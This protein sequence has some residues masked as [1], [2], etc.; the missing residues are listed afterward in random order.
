MKINISQ[1]KITEG[2]LIIPAI[3]TDTPFIEI[4]QFQLSISNKIFSAKKDT[5]YIIEKES[6]IYIV[7]GLGKDMEHKVL[8]DSFR[9][10]SFKNKDLFSENT[11]IYI[12]EFFSNKNITSIVNGLYLGIYE[13][14][15]FKTDKKIEHPILNENFELKFYFE[16]QNFDNSLKNIQKGIKIAQAQIAAMTL[17]DLPANIITPTYLANE[18]LNFAKEF[19]TIK[20]TIF[21]RK[22]CEELGLDAFLAVAKGSTEEPKFIILEYTPK[23]ST[24]NNHIG[25]VGKGITFDTGGLN[26]KTQGMYFMKCDMSGAATVFGAL[27][28]IASLEIPT[29]VT[30]ILPC[31]E[32]S[33]DANS[34]KPSDIISSYSKKSIEITDTDAEGRLALADGISFMIKNYNPDILLDFAT[35]TGSCVQTFGYEC[36]AMFSNNEQIKEA[37]SKIGLEIDEKVWPLP[38]WNNYESDNNSD[39]ADIKNYSMKS[40]AGAISAAKFIEFF[41]E[42]HPAWMHLDIASVA[43]G[44]G[45]Y[46]KSKYAS[47]FGV[48][49]IAEYVE[50][51]K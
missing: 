46:G 14:N 21:D 18:A 36:A 26:I 12:P 28:L 27:K 44:D 7:V 22:K 17:V 16:K 11:Q 2:T 6:K 38:L 50:S 1:Q 3:E 40:V 5:F 31:T 32:N 34:F 23:N 48:H 35:L 4:P 41:T 24:S 33:I 49:L 45:E 47:A 13:L 19:S 43:F 10:I 8:K 25:L 9:R 30:A 51:L 39:I 20:T 29:K 15:H 37:F 42:N